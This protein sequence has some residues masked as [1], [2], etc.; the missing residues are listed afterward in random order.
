MTAGELKRIPQFYRAIH[1]F[2][3]TLN[4]FERKGFYKGRLSGWDYSMQWNM[5]GG[6]PIIG[7]YEMKQEIY[8][9]AA[10]LNNLKLA[11]RA[12]VNANDME[13]DSNVQDRPLANPHRIHIFALTWLQM[14][15][16]GMSEDEFKECLLGDGLYELGFTM[17]CGNSFEK[18]Y[19][20]LDGFF[21]NRAF[22]KIL[23]DIDIKTLGDAI[24]SQWR[25]W[26]HWSDEEMQ[27]KDFQWF[28]MGLTRLAELTQEK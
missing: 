18:K 19:S 4:D 10:R 20:G 1:T 27:D 14:L 24:F 7:F 9:I 17:D 21:E 5:G 25:R 12:K 23:K 8:D 26:N 6:L 15:N 2:S 3:D 11:L 13:D 16:K 22:K 28:V